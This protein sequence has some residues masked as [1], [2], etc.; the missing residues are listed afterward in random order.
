MKTKL[1]ILLSIIA[2]GSLFPAEIRKR[3]DLQH[4]KILTSFDYATP[5]A[6]EFNGLRNWLGGIKEGQVLLLNIAPA[7]V[8]NNV[9]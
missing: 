2:S 1:I 9:M 5:S 8:Y 3:G 7:G 4:R 6:F